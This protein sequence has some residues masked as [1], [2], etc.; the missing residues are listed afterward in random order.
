METDMAETIAPVTNKPIWIDLST[1]D[2]EGARNFYS[3]VLGWNVEVNPDPQY[4]GYALA[5]I[6]GKDAAGIGPKMMEQAPTAW[7]VYIGTT[8]S[9][10]LAKKVKAAGGNVVVEPMAVGDQGRMTVFQDPAGAFISSWQPQAMLGFASG[11]AGTFGWAELNARGLDKAAAFYE[12]VF[13]WTAKSGP[14]GPE[15]GTYTQF[16]IGDETVAGGSE[17]NPMVPAEVPSYWMVYFWAADVDA[18][19]A[20]AIAAGATEMLSPSDLPGGR[21]AILADPQG[22]FFG[23]LQMRSW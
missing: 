16:Q 6:D 18:T 3:K 17:M 7:S 21:L 1:S 8:D 22:A 2:P 23:L 19:Y 9:D 4:G 5:K 11:V 15:G 10:E 20:A 14:L 13:G 12:S